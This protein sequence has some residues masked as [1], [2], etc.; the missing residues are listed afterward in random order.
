MRDHPILLIH[1]DILNR[2][3][4]S[5]HP[6]RNE[7]K[8]Q[9]IMQSNLSCL[10]F[11]KLDHRLVFLVKYILAVLEHEMPKRQKQKQLVTHTST[12]LY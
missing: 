10:K 11:L 4:I 3:G 1:G 9:L 8:R 7:E 12:L 2:P 6:L 5:H